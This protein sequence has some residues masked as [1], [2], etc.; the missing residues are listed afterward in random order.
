M[1]DKAVGIV[2]RNGR[3]SKVDTDQRKFILNAVTKPDPYVHASS[4]D[5][6]FRRGIHY[7]E[8][9]EHA[10]VAPKFES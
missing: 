9:G 4:L 2:E 5:N 8:G 10:P 6:S 7:F 3:V 1:N